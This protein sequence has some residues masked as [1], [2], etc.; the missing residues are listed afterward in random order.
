M[1]DT[2]LTDAADYPRSLE[3][4]CHEAYDFARQLERRAIAAEKRLSEIE[5]QLNAWHSVFKTSQLSH[6]SARLE[7]AEKEHDISEYGKMEKSLAAAEKRADEADAKVLKMVDR[8]VVLML[9]LDEWRGVANKIKQC[10][11]DWCDAFSDFISESDVESRD[12][13]NAMIGREKGEQNTPIS[14]SSAASSGSGK[15]GAG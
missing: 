9:R 10:V 4:D 8:E 13:Y 7:A 6:A 15:G 5:T 14:G 12:A 2:P 11:D 3:C 1:T